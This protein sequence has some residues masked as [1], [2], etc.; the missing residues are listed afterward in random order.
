M[1]AVILTIVIFLILI[2][3]HEFGHFIAA[4]LSGVSVL[5][6]AIGMGPAIWKK[7]GKET[8]YSLRALPIGG[9]CKLEGEDEDSEKENAFN[10]QKLWKRFIVISAGAI[11]NLILGFVVFLFVVGMEGSI[12]TTT[13]KTIDTRAYI[14]EAGILEGDK[15]IKING[16]KVNFYR[17]ISYYLSDRKA[18]ETVEV[19]VKRN[20][21]KLDFS[22]TPSLQSEKYIYD[23]NGVSVISQVNG[24]EEQRYIAYSD[25]ERENFSQYAGEEREQSRYIIG[26]SPVVEPVSVKNIF[27]ESYGYTVFVVKMVYDALGDLFTGKT[28]IEQ[29]SGPVGVATAVDTA[30]SQKGYEIPNVLLL[31]AMLTINLGIF[32]LLPLPA[33]D[34]GRLVFLVIELVFRK[35]VP[36]DKEGIVHAIGMILLLLLAA[37]ILFNDVLKLF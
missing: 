3:L 36:R 27:S 10:N 9:Y 28:G 16:R 20:G 30:V 33:L 12:A 25:E 8:L 13:I 31:L 35:P 21:E 19:S 32:N 34:G 1:V 5:E 17:D 29:F 23:E 15:I 18:D 11:L 37:V 26:F 7:Q 6:F 22:V 14:D 24:V 4:K 2:S